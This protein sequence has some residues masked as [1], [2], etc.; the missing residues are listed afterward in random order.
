MTI[1]STPLPPPPPDIPHGHHGGTHKAGHQ[2]APKGS[3]Q[4]QE[5]PK[6]QQLEQTQKP[7]IAGETQKLQEGDGPEMLPDDLASDEIE[8]NEFQSKWH[9]PEIINY[10]GSPYG[11]STKVFPE[12]DNRI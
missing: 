12:N 4:A 9:D 3:P 6:Q 7:Q 8:N 5:P 1:E 11:G 10:G 2:E